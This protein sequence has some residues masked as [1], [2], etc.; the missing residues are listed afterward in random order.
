MMYRS[1]VEQSLSDI[2][3]KEGIFYK[4]TL[5]KRQ[6]LEAE[7]SIVILGDVELGAKVI[8]KGSVIIIGTLYGSVCAGA[9]GDTSAYVVAL[10]MQSKY[11]SIGDIVAKRQIIYQESLNIKGPKIAVIDGNRIYLDPLT[12]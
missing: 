1:V 12:D 10:S 9:S 2:Y 7:E 4:G 8:A 11:L 6:I 3:K 5:R